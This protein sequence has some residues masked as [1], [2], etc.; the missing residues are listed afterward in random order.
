MK[1]A[2]L[3]LMLVS[4]I[5]AAQPGE[6][7]PAGIQIHGFVSAGAFYSTDNNYIG[8]SSRGSAELF[9]VGLN[10]T[11][12]PVERLRVGMQLFAARTGTIAD[13]APRIDWAFLDY[14][15]RRWL[16]VR[17]GIIR[18]P[19]GLYN[20]F[21][22]VDAARTP[23]LMPQAV[24]SLR[25]RDLLIS[26]TGFSGYGALDLGRAGTLDYQ[27]WGGSLN[28]PRSALELVDAEVVSLET[29]YV[30][31]GQVMWN[32][33]LDG[34][35]VGASWIRAAID[36][37][38]QIGQATIDAFI[39]AGI[40][41][42]G[43]DGK[44]FVAQ[45]PTSLYVG[46]AEY[47]R[48]EWSF[49]AEYVRQRTRQKLAPALIPPVEADSERFYVM[50]NRQISRCWAASGYYSVIHADVNDR[51]GRDAMRFPIRHRAFQ[52]DAALTVRFDINDNWLVKGEAHFIDGAADLPLEPNP[53]PERYWGMFLFK[54]TVTF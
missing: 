32:T 50:A 30:V 48:G 34:L 15:F 24:Y 45:R 5:A 38:L 19:L 26:H 11:T 47:V 6:E 9:E 4:R 10:F 33:P 3:A 28:I 17:A 49:A 13:G 35:R 21:T 23:I 37:D 46:S 20:E 53:D 22:D 40:A 43:Y 14:R 7:S 29:R 12:E 41:P 25:S 2:A 42:P 1:Y 51:G 31:G 36:F 54:T 44:L 27:G 18:I 8:E 39:A 52:R 16:K